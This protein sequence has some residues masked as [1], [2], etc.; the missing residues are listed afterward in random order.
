MVLGSKCDNLKYP[1]EFEFAVFNCTTL[2][3]LRFKG[4]LIPIGILFPSELEFFN[5][6]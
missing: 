4:F 1:I 2:G 3:S 6:S 5:L